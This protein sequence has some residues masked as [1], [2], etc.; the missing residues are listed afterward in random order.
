VGNA[1]E[2]N[3]LAGADTGVPTRSGRSR[4]TAGRTAVLA[5]PDEPCPPKRRT[6]AGISE[7][8]LVEAAFRRVTDRHHPH[9]RRE[10]CRYERT[11]CLPATP[12][13]W[14]RIWQSHTECSIG[15]GGRV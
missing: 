7:S 9:A 8:D 5:R 11:T 3:R 13:G 10:S 4:V 2:P 15:C 12:V 6:L 1:D 14:R